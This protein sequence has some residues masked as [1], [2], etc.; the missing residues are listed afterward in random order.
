MF[1]AF[2]EVIAAFS[3]RRDGNMSLN[4]GDAS[5]SLENRNRFL[6]KLKIDQASLVCAKQVH[7]SGIV[8]VKQEDRGKGAL[9]YET[10]IDATDAFITDEKKIALSVFT[11]DCLSVFLYDPE[12]PAIGLVHAGWRSTSEYIV[13]NAIKAMQKNFFTNPEK[14]KASFGPAIRSCCYEVEEKLNR[15][16]PS[17]LVKR[18]GR[19][20]LDIAGVNKAQLLEAGVREYNITD[21]AICTSCQNR[22]FFSFRKEGK[23]SGRM[24]SVIMLK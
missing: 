9:S 24:V 13:K 7:S 19:Y 11:A 15:Y 14:L 18:E 8:Y 20:Y 1:D 16:F 12:H 2:E 22:E 10:S 21:C 23:S 6:N 4:Y 17:G 5:S 3:Q